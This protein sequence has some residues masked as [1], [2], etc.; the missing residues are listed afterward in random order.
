MS[1][2]ITIMP[3]PP[4]P[5]RKKRVAA[6]ARVSCGK[7]AMLHSLSAQVSHYSD[8]IRNHG[9]WI[10]AGV[11]AD[12]AKTGTKD[13]RENFQRLITDCRAGKIENKTRYLIQFNDCPLRGV[14]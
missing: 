14:A 1:G 4:K 5:E 3:T 9:D 13:S 6:Y 12:E 10:Y 8:F 2:T 7:D 11:Y